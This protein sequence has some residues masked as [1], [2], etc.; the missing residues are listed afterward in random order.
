MSEISLKSLQMLQAQ[1][2]SSQWALI[3]LYFIKRSEPVKKYLTA[4][5]IY[6]IKST[7]FQNRNNIQCLPVNIYYNYYLIR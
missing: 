2:T 1:N 7:K 3:V 4:K 5:M 6:F